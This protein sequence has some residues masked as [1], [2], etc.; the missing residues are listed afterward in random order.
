VKKSSPTVSVI[1]P[2]HNRAHLVRRAIESVR[3]QSYG[4]LEIIVVD[5]CSLDGTR[6]VI[7]KIEDKRLT[8]V[9]HSVKKGGG[10]ARNT[11]IHL[12]KG[13]FISFLDDDDEWFQ[14]KISLQLDAFNKAPLLGL[15]YCGYHYVCGETGA[16]VRT[17][18]PDKAGNIYDELLRYNCIGTTSSAMIK[19]ECIEKVGPF[20]PK[21]RSCQDWDLWLR[22]SKD[23]P[24]GY[25]LRP[26]VYFCIHEKRITHDLTAKIQGRARLLG[27]LYNEIK[28]RDK[29]VGHHLLNIGYLYCH[30][31]DIEKG[32][33]TLFK[34]IKKAP[35]E[36]QFYKYIF[37]SIFGAKFYS[38]ILEKK[39]NCLTC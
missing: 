19:R 22:I 30:N 1:I 21:L 39:R 38:F 20:D 10:S 5:D 6:E 37:A 34:G 16:I 13:S 12:S 8:Y 27:K 2:T 33:R 23:Y 17:Y 35:L 25:V 11:G 28:D 14:D 4:D 31:G 26:L 36:T 18:S 32:K 24:V 7:E 15:V 29:I 3:S 9:R